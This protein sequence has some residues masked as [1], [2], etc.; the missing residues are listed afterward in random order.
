MSQENNNE[1]KV[2]T[3]WLSLDR[4][5]SK[6]STMEVILI[7]AEGKVGIN[8]TPS[9]NPEG[10]QGRPQAGVKAFDY[11]RT[12][13]FTLTN[14]EVQAIVSAADQGI[15]Q[16]SQISFIHQYNG[17]SNT[18]RIGV[19]NNGPMT[20]N[21]NSQG[22]NVSHYMIP[23]NYNNGSVSL[24]V[25]FDYFISLLR[26]TLNNVVV[27]KGGLLKE[28]VPQNRNGNGGGYNN[29]QGYNKYNQASQNNN[30]QNNNGYNQNQN[31]SRNNNNQGYR[32]QNNQ[33]NDQFSNPDDSLEF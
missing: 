32:Q 12:V 11:E 28:Y 24:N 29:N 25:E 19:Y 30:H 22:N 5:Y 17:N 6:K 2:P 33:P 18:F 4:F 27:V 23:T 16:N 1:R 9:I 8:I 31:Y 3:Y 21:I 26:S 14:R 20:I 13:R 10:N 7:D 15:I